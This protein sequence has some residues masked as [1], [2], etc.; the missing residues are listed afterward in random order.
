MLLGAMATQ[1]PLL[2]IFDDVHWADVPTLRLLRHRA[3]RRREPGDARLHAARRRAGGRRAAAGARGD[4]PRAD[5]RDDRPRGLDETET[6]EL[7]VACGQAPAADDVVSRLRERTAGNPFYIEET[8]HSVR[9]LSARAT[10]T[11]SRSRRCRAAST[12]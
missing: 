10:A 9:D 6:A 5:R 4:P 7:V 2:V 3:V 12:R 11:G 8:L 1:A